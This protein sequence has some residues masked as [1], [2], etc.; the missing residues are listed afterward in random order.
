LHALNNIS[1]TMDN[2]FRDSLHLLIN[3]I[4]EDIKTK[5]EDLKKEMYHDI[6][7]L[8]KCNK[9]MIDEKFDNL[10]VKRTMEAYRVLKDKMTIYFPEN[11]NYED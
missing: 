9:K 2:D 7:Q 4:K 8:L 1:K 6:N 10:G 3:S 11:H 5:D